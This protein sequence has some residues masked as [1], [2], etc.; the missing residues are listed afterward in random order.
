ME[1]KKIV[2]WFFEKNTSLYNGYIEENI[3]INKLL[4]YS[5]IMF[6]S[7]FGKYLLD[8]EFERWDKGPVLKSLYRDY[9]Y[10]KLG[11]KIRF[12]K[13]EILD[14]EVEKVL[15]IINLIYSD[16]T[17]K[18][19]SDETHKHNLWKEAMKNSKI[20][21]SKIDSNLKKQ[22][23]NYYNLYESFDFKNIH[24]VKIGGNKYFYDKNNLEMTKEIIGE[25]E[26]INDIM[27][28]QFIELIDNEVVF[29]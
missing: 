27:E 18:E 4:Y 23:L 1:V 16:K 10:N 29:L 13:D 12:E 20:D 14:E 28:P 11:Y 17:S 22:M 8:E 15:N 24:T 25:L 9:R 19:L 6:Y 26:Q 7:V 21:I 5:S 2:K 3:K